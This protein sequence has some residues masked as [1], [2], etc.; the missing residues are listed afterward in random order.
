MPSSKFML[1]TYFKN[2]N[3]DIDVSNDLGNFS[4]AVFG[5]NLKI[6]KANDAEQF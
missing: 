1:Q 2:Y 6:I 4:L 5:I 3:Q